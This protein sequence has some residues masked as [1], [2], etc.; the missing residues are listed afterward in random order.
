MIEQALADYPLARESP[1]DRPY[2][3]LADLYAKLG[4]PEK[5]R[6]MIAEYK[7][8]VPDSLRRNDSGLESAEGDLHLAEG[9]PREAL[10][11]YRRAWDLSSCT[12]CLLADIGRAFDALG[13]ADSAIAYYRKGNENPA[14]PGSVFRDSRELAF[15]YRRLGELYEAKGDKEAALGAYGQFADLWKDA[16]PELRPQV[17]EIR[18]RMA[19]LAGEEK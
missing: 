15:T 14:G 10:A 11:S 4:Q 5:A 9:R 8:A 7:A 17:A 12:N 1:L 13:E 3:W 6:R 2:L 16:D 18:Q 19:R